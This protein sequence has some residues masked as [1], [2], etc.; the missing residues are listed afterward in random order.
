MFQDSFAAWKD[1]DNDKF[2]RLI[3]SYIPLLYEQASI[4]DITE[5]NRYQPV[6][7]TVPTLTNHIFLCQVVEID[8]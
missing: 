7:V 1:I 3:A 5:D 8:S 6:W 2:V 4:M